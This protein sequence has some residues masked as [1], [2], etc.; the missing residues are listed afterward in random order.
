MS[1][2]IIMGSAFLPGQVMDPL[3]VALR[4]RGWTAEWAAPTSAATAQAAADTYVAAA[5]RARATVAIAHSNA[6][7]FVPAVTAGSTVTQVVFLDAIIPPLS[8]GTW[9]VVPAGLREMLTSSAPHGL[10]PPWTQWWPEADVAALFPDLATFRRVDADAPRV[11][12]SYLSSSATA[13]KDWSVGLDL[14]YVAFGATYA[15]AIR[16]AADARWPVR[17]LQLGHLGML[18]EPTTVA[19]AILSLQPTAR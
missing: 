11:P 17:I 2:A 8:G 19:D 5:H 16:V 9:P 18:Q 6:G 4:R 3:A 10:L 12:L 13:A 7:N 14:A 1:R 15:D